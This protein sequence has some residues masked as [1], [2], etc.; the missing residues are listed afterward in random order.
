MELYNHSPLR[1]LVATKH[2]GHF[3]F[4]IYHSDG[5]LFKQNTIYEFR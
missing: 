3:A 5:S 1:L 4:Y 2:M